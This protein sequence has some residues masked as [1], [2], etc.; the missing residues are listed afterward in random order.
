MN[1]IPRKVSAQLLMLSPIVFGM[2]LASGLTLWATEDAAIASEIQ[3]VSDIMASSQM[4]AL[5]ITS[6]TAATSTTLPTNGMRRVTGVGHLSAPSANASDSQPQVTS[7]SQLSDVQPTDWAFQALQSLVERYGCIAGYPDGS[8]RGNRAMSRYEFAAGLNACL[9]RINELIAAGLEPLATREDLAVLQRLQEEFAAELATLRGRVDALEART[10]ELEANQFSTTTKLNAVTVFHVTDLGFSG[11]LEREIGA[12]DPI[13]G[14]QLSET[15]TDSASEPNFSA[16]SWINLTSSFSGKDSLNVQLDVSTGI[17]PANLFVSSGLFNTWGTP[18]TQQS[19]GD[20]FRLRELFYA[21]PAFDDKVDF[22]VGPRINIYR[23]FDGNPYT[24]ILGAIDSFNSSGSTQFASLDRGAGAVAIVPFGNFDF[25][26]GY[27]AENNEFLPGSTASD[28]SET[29]GLFGGVNTLVSQ[30]SY[31]PSS[32]FALNLL[33]A[34]TNN[35][36][37][38]GDGLIGGAL[39][40]PGGGLFDDGASGGG[41]GSAAANTYIANFSW[42]FLPN[43]AMFGRYSY[44]DYALWRPSDEGGGRIGD[45]V[46]QSFQAGLAFPDLGKEGA[47]AALSYLIPYSYIDGREFVLSGAGGPG[48]VQWEIE[49]AYFYPLTDNI[50]LSP[51]VYIINN[52]NNFNDNPTVVV[53]NLRTQFN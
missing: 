12:R 22:V 21:F 13:T 39:S 37:P 40:E 26:L 17:S 49:A 11:D 53:G 24:F 10:A 29:R 44:G 42:Q 35:T 48:G 23:H 14:E 45:V 34:R 33:Y 20:D 9:D 16:L 41:I 51:R 43:V 2:A 28:P 6:P 52:P 25:R 15:L 27:M 7:I 1:D 47:M 5:D 4:S 38:G 3:S 46:S 32:D 8:F 31:R 50:S 19:S 18:F 36:P 30:V